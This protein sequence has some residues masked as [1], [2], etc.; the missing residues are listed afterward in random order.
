[1][2][3]MSPRAKV[4][5]SLHFD[6]GRTY[7][8]GAI[9]SIARSA[10]T[11]VLQ[12]PLQA[13]CFPFFEATKV[14]D[15]FSGMALVPA[16]GAK[17]ESPTKKVR[18]LRAIKCGSE[19]LLENSYNPDGRLASVRYF[20]GEKVHYDWDDVGRALHVRS[21]S[22]REVEIKM[23]GDDLPTALVYNKDIQFQFDY[24]DA[25]N[26]TQVCYPDGVRTART[27]GPHG[28]LASVT[29]GP[30]HVSLRWNESRELEG[31]TVAGGDTT[32][33]SLF[34]AK[35]IQC[36]LTLAGSGEQTSCYRI[37][38]L[39][40]WRMNDGKTLQ[41]MLTPWGERFRVAA[42]GPNGPESVWSSAGLRHFD[43]NRVGGFTAT[44]HPDGSRSALYALEGQ[45][46]SLLVNPGGV[47]LLELD[48]AGRLHKALGG[49]GRYSLIDYTREGSVKRFSTF[50]ETFSV[51]RNHQG[52][53]AAIHSDCG[54]TCRLVNS[55]HGDLIGLV[56]EGLQRNNAEDF[57]RML[58]FLWQC[59]GLRRIHSLVIG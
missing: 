31:F 46:R 5:I 50:I 11:S 41:E 23:R 33:E 58:K 30:L 36:D 52:L 7:K 21:H 8:A 26:I 15:W 27:L 16:N 34:R 47:T 43:Y 38:P 56:A 2:K 24:D 4:E 32:F 49:D 40:A 44:T 29:C 6:Q 48:G 45:N 14:S 17:D 20:D 42:S 3:A 53:L 10:Q 28:D 39:G 59:L 51:F 19:T 55:A 35:R 57:C 9:E 1:M 18:R 37:H 54:Y 12:D 13:S 25:G 22:G